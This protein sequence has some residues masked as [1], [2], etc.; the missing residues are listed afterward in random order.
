MTSAAAWAGRFR[1]QDSRRRHLHAC[2]PWMSLERIEAIVD[3][4]MRSCRHHRHAGRLL[5]N[6]AM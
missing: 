4:T 3:R 6:I 2:D 1:S 5:P